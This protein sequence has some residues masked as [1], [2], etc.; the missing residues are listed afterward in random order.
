M[1]PA[2]KSRI[3]FFD[4]VD[5]YRYFDPNTNRAIA[6]VKKRSVI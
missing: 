3:V 5:G 4:N 1:S 6:V 2:L